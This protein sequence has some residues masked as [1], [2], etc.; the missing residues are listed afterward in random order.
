MDLAA[1]P[2][3]VDLLAICDTMTDAVSCEAASARAD[4][5]IANFVLAVGAS[6]ALELICVKH[7]VG[8]GKYAYSAVHGLEQ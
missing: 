4:G 6:A 2:F 8:K 5:A 1:Y 3:K 7:L